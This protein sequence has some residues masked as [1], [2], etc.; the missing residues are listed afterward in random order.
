MYKMWYQSPA[1]DNACAG[2]AGGSCPPSFQTGLMCLVEIL[3]FFVAD[4]ETIS[5]KEKREQVENADIE[6]QLVHTSDEVSAFCADFRFF[7]VAQFV[8]DEKFFLHIMYCF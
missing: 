5:E 4:T 7:G 2:V 1:L 6:R 3:A 8:L